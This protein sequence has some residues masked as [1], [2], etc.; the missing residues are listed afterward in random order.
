MKMFENKVAVVTG[1]GGTLCSEIAIRLSLEGAKVILVGRTAE[2]LQK[3][4]DKI[5]ALGGTPAVIYPC[6]VTD[7]EAVEKLAEA[8]EALGG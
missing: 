7:K 6:D 4:F 3:T 1:A 2:K 8:A 5:T